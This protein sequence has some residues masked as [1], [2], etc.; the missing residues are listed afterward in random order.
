MADKNTRNNRIKVKSIRS[1]PNSVNT[2]QRKEKI[3]SNK[4]RNSSNAS[5]K[6]KNKK[7]QKNQQI[8]KNNVYSIEQVRNQ[9]Y[10]KNN[11]TN[12]RSLHTLRNT[13]N[14][15][16][17]QNKKR[18]SRKTVLYANI[19]SIIIFIAILSYFTVF[20]VKFFN[21]SSINYSYVEIG[22]IDSPKTATGIIIRDEQVYT[23]TQDGVLSFNVS[24][25]DRV[26]VSTNIA[27]IKSLE[28]LYEMEEQLEA[29]NQE[30][31]DL[32]ES[33]AELSWFSEDAEKINF[34][35]QSIVDENS[36]Q[37]TQNDISKLYEMS[38][39]ISANIEMR[40][41]ILLSETTGSLSELAVKRK[42]QE[43]KINQNSSTITNLQSGIISY[44][45]DGLEEMLTLEN[46]FNLTKEQTKMDTTLQ[47]IKLQVA[48]GEPIFKIIN[49]NNWYIATYV[50]SA[51]VEG[52]EEGQT[53][54]IY[55][56][57]NLETKELE[58]EVYYIEK[59]SKET[60]MILKLTKNMLDYINTR[61]ITFELD[62][63]FTGFKINNNSI[64]EVNLLK[65][66]IDFITEEN[67]IIK[68]TENSNVTLNVN[69]YYEPDI[70]DFAY[71][72][73]EIGVINIGDTILN[74]NDL[75]QTYTIS[76]ILTTKGVYVINTGITK[77]VKINLQNSVSN[78]QYTILD[79]SLNN[80]LTVYDNI[81][82]DIQ[83]IQNEQSIYN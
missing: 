2:N 78:D 16:A 17:N 25:N 10:N 57:E 15:K 75:T 50:K 81:I 67:S 61:S 74:P 77:Y 20:F 40:T 3:F 8:E 65:I 49:S 29:I 58:A 80:N 6:I 43:E 37:L 72:P 53:K 73:I 35:I 76:E 14:S 55:V 19:F 83:N 11:R 1:K 41:Q 68:Q 36:Y 22:T 30:I 26:R 62:K 70:L 47:S 31:I 45:I 59:G 5:N 34:Q 54:S 82:L 28:V 44:Y 79:P 9:Y 4:A 63:V 7:L 69:V 48:E 33:R 24:N 18:N 46:M 12:I 51:F 66:P 52:W 38:N 23:A 42:E 32:Q 56:K 60:F 21:Q 71:I 27:T 39:S 13:S 64:A